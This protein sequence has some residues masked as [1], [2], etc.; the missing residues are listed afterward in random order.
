MAETAA[1]PRETP[2]ANAASRRYGTPTATYRL[3]LHAG[4]GFEQA[5]AI[6]P[7]LERLGVSH[8]YLSPI[9][10]A[11]PGSSHGYDVLDHGTVN[12]ELGG[13][14]ALHALGAELA[15]RDM[16]LVVDIVPNHV[17][18]AKGTNPWFRDVLRYGQASAYA[19][20]FD[21]DWE[22]QPQMTTGV[23]VFPVLGQPFGAALEA[24]EIQLRLTD[25]DFV[26]SY[27]DYTLP[28]SPRSY[29][30]VIGVPPVTLSEGEMGDPAALSTVMSAAEQLGIAAPAECDGLLGDLRRAIEGEA[31]IQE[32]L[33]GRLEDLNGRVGEAASFDELEAIVL[34][35]H[36]RLAYWRVSGEELNY[37]RFFDVND[38]AAIRVERDDVFEE[39]HRLLFELV[40]QG[41][42]TGVRVDHIDG[43]YRPQAYLERLKSRLAE[44]AGGAAVPVYVEKILQA[45]EAL[46]PEWT[47]DGTTGYD[48]MAVVDG[49]FV[50]GRAEKEMTDSYHRM[51]GGAVDFREVAYL[52]R[53]QVAETAFAGEIN[54]LAM[55]LYR[56]AQR[57]RL[58]RDT[59]LRSLRE[60]I[61]AVLA[62]MPVYRTYL[63]DGEPRAGDGR[64]IG[65]ALEE[66]RRRDPLVTPEAVRF[67]RE[68]LLLEHQDL[69]ADEHAARVHFRRRFQQVA[70]P[71]MAKGMEDTAYFRYNRLLALNEVGA[72]PGRFGVRPEDAH[73]YFLDRARRWP[74]AMSAG[75]THDTKRSE[76]VRAR[77]TALTLWAK[78]WKVESRAWSRLNA[79]HRRAGGDGAAPDANTEYYIYQT[80][81]ATFP[82]DGANAEYRARIREHVTKAMRE[83]KTFTSWT[84]PD[85]EYE[86]GCLGFVDAVLS[87]RIAARFIE[88]LGTF[89]ERVRWAGE[90]HAL[91]GLAVRM[92]APGFPDIYQGCEFPNVALTDP[93]NRRAVDF[94]VREEVLSRLG[95]GRAWPGDEAGP[96]ATRL[97]LTR[98]LLALRGEYKDVF[99]MGG[100]RPLWAE[101]QEGGMVFGFQREHGGVRVAT[102]VTR[103]VKDE[104]RWHGTVLGLGEGRWREWLTGD[105]VGGGEVSC[106]QLLGRRPCVVLVSEG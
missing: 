24:G 71:V 106:E 26:V 22:G 83:M 14:P 28:L 33:A 10:R 80:L 79:R 3:Q 13:L 76:D 75:S 61:G 29:R 102:V 65:L 44:A 55:Q 53:R 7:Y 38:L 9:F 19:D 59:T 70:G 27:Y 67:L 91:A 57:Q 101:G 105:E 93:D 72:E 11:T 78:E 6:V 73:E 104:P 84:D 23:L 31:A 77:L 49:L 56:L 34:E 50:D 88:R 99:D 41:I 25:G 39:T 103:L 66:A 46:P 98:R 64:V 94:A 21:I 58:Y 54:V 40:R 81:V 87:E 100:Y 42:V 68:V 17:G 96:E 90:R 16:G 12:P 95:G 8:L 82:E 52:S 32:W 4:F 51:V 45:E 62:C 35:Q 15:A 30:R 2:A 20:Y 37:R 5:R 47:T 92:T 1:R 43:L 97:W 63:V 86:A 89:A 85:E 74:G 36:Y 48:A 18:V 69:A 60:T